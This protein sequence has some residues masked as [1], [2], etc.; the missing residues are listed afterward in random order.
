[1]PKA[2]LKKR[3]RQASPITLYNQETGK[4]RTWKSRKECAESLGTSFQNLM[5]LIYHINGQRT[6]CG[7]WAMTPKP[8]KDHSVTLYNVYTGE[9]KTWDNPTECAADLD[10]NV[11]TVYSLVNGKTRLILGTWSLTKEEK[12]VED[13]ENIDDK[14]L[15]MVIKV[16]APVIRKYQN[17][18]GDKSIQVARGIMDRM[19]AREFGVK[20]IN[21]HQHGFDGEYLNGIPFEHKN[22]TYD[23]E[24]FLDGEFQDI[25]PLRLRK[26][27]GGSLNI[28]SAFDGFCFPVYSVV[29]NSAN[30]ADVL[31]EGQKNF[32]QR[33]VITLDQIL[34]AGGKIVTWNNTPQEAYKDITATYPNCGLRMS[35]IYTLDKAKDVAKQVMNL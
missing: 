22:N 18:T 29:F 13:F 6:I 2:K 8:P 7:K 25:S 30:T 16:A 31:V 12:P 34:A 19:V 4:P 20:R 17:K 24:R 10:V 3:G 23:R 14:T 21:T 1:M 9:A 5:N 27:A 32:R 26:F 15:D 11:N 28:V 35:D 33:A